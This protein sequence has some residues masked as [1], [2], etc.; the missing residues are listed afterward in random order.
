MAGLVDAV[1]GQAEL[2]AL[3]DDERDVFEQWLDG[4]EATCD[5]LS[6]WRG[7]HEYECFRLEADADAWAAEGM[8]GSDGEQ[9]YDYCLPWYELKDRVDQDLLANGDPQHVWDARVAAVRVE[10]GLPLGDYL[11]R[12][13]IIAY[14]ELSGK[15]APW[16]DVHPTGRE[17]VLPLPLDAELPSLPPVPPPPDATP[18]PPYLPPP[19]QPPQTASQKVP[20]LSDV[21][22]SG[23]H[24]DFDE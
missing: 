12:D 24:A 3:E 23:G 11:M 20:P 21:I 1:V 8:P 22:E 7:S 18:P 13:A 2:E 14:E 6:D 4:D 10:R 16:R 9:D 5:A 19:T 17:V 15:R